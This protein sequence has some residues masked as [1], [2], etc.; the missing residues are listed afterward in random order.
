MQMTKH[1][2]ILEVQVVDLSAAEPAA[3]KVGE[4]QTCGSQSYTDYDFDLS[5]Y[6]GKRSYY[7]YRNL[8]Y[9]N[10]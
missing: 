2:C 9:R 3:V 7:S 4:T 5:D 1:Q 8:S 10:R 6:V